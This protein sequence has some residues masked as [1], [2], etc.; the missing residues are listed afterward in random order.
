MYDSGNNENQV[1]MKSFEKGLSRI[2]VIAFLSWVV[3][4]NISAQAKPQRTGRQ[5]WIVQGEA[6]AVGQTVT[7]KMRSSSHFDQGRL[8][9]ITDSTLSFEN[10]IP[11]MVI[12]VRHQ[13]IEAFK[14]QK[15]RGHVAGNVLGGIGLALIGGLMIVVT[16]AY[17]S[18]LN[19]GSTPPG[20]QGTT[21]LGWAFV[22]GGIVCII[23]PVTPE[24]QTVYPSQSNNSRGISN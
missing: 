9:M 1:E 10:N 21:V 5:V 11:G 19:S 17:V 18:T 15:K 13:D 3:H 14:F 4:G 8:I 20:L 22:A 12:T 6:L 24:T 23:L 7:Y 16:D 2:I